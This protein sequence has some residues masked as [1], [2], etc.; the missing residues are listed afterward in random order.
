MSKKWMLPAFSKVRHYRYWIPL[1]LMNQELFPVKRNLKNWT[2][3]A[4]SIG[5]HPHTI[6]SCFLECRRSSTGWPLIQSSNQKPDLATIKPKEH[7]K[8]MKG[9]TK[10][11]LRCLCRRNR[12]SNH[13][14][15]K[16]LHQRIKLNTSLIQST[17]W[18]LNLAKQARNARICKNGYVGKGISA[19]IALSSARSLYAYVR[20]AIRL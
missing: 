8:Q 17:N 10:Q 5:G 9:L 16:W 12:V 6:G 2:K 4:E 11:Q 1:E 18:K 3:E 13:K 7:T 19:M 14:M 20:L 15:T